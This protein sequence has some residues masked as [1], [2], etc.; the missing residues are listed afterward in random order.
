MTVADIKRRK[1][2][3]NIVKY[4][5]DKVRAYQQTYPDCKSRKSAQ[6]SVS[7]ALNKYPE[8]IDNVSNMLTKQGLGIGKL[9]SKLAKL[10]DWN[11]VVIT[12]KGDTVSVPDG[13]LQLEATKTAYRLH[14]E[15]TTGNSSVVDNR[16][17]NVTMNSADTDKL[18]SVAS[19]L[20]AMQAAL[21]LDNGDQ[22]GSLSSLNRVRG[23]DQE[24]STVDGSNSTVD[25]TA[26]TDN[27]VVDGEFVEG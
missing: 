12:P 17:V 20:K 18:A 8:I 2:A 6:N 11:K 23:E 5:G 10:I 19:D 24:D 14:G 7:K 9:N 27:N 25:S 15:L 1:L 3:Q 13:N 22:T 4:E 16:Q 26:D 21:T